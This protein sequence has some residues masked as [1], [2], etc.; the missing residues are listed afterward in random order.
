VIWEEERLEKVSEP[1]SETKVGL[2]QLCRMVKTYSAGSNDRLASHDMTKN[3]TG[4]QVLRY[5]GPMAITES[6]NMRRLMKRRTRSSKHSRSCSGRE[7]PA[8]NPS[9]ASFTANLCV[10]FPVH[11]YMSTRVRGR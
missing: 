7:T 10:D 5:V 1:S 6:R 11:R 9:H 3:G 8:T 4:V 2:W